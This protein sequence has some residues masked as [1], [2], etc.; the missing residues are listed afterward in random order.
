MSKQNPADAFRN[1]STKTKISFGI[2]ATLYI[3]FV[4]W[5]QSPIWLIGLIVVFD[6]YI[7]K[8]VKWAFWKKRY[9]PGEKRNLLLDWIDALVFALIVA[10]VART[11]FLEAYVIP[12]SSME[13]SL[14]VGDYLFV[15]KVAYGPRIPLTPVSFPLV[16]NQISLPVVGTVNSFSEILKLPYRR[17]TGFGRVKRN[18]VVV[19]NFPNGDTVVKDTPEIIDYHQQKRV[20]G[21]STLKQWLKANNRPLVSRPMD[22]TDHYVKR[23]VAIAGDTLEIRHCQLFINGQLAAD[24]PGMEYDYYLNLKEPLNPK[25]FSQLNLS[26]EDQQKLNS[27]YASL[28][29]T[30]ESHEK[31]K[32][33]SS[34]I[35]LSKKEETRFNR[36]CFP[37][38]AAY[39]WT[40]DNYGPLWVPKQGA[41]VR[42]DRANICLYERIITAYEHNTLQVE[43]DRIM[44]NGTETDSYTFKMDYYFMMGDNRHGSYD[45][46]SWGFVPENH[47]VG[48][49]AFIW[50]SSDKDKSFPANIRWNRLFNSIK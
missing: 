7:T 2:A 17:L 11:F 1:A 35:S 38:S 41:T 46:R 13:K 32:N 45:S 47:I 12:S 25:I 31:L 23:C 39:P 10:T 19:F 36:E 9:K 18:D 40:V 16:H 48:K 14:L 50:F 28:P 33:I 43:D 5:L 30:R 29:L 22:K 20:V 8:W 34:V 49:P 37:F 15:S 26:L 24:L 3:L 4:V 21:E 44:I 6:L 42:I 27:Q